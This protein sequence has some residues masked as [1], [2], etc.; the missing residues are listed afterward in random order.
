MQIIREAEPEEEIRRC[1]KVD[2][3]RRYSIKL[4]KNENL[5]TARKENPE[6]LGTRV[7]LGMSL[8]YEIGKVHEKRRAIMRVSFEY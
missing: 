1:S 5:K 7:E 6:I 3:R 8:V 2:Q 4:N